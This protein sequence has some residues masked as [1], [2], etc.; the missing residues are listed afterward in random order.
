[1]KKEKTKY[2]ELSVYLVLRALV[3]AIMIRQ[4][5]EGNFENVFVCILTLILFII[6]IIIDRKL[7][8]KLPST[9]E[10]IIYFF[11]FAAWILGE[12]Q[13]FYGIFSYWDTILH[14]INGFICAAV[15]FA[16]I[17]ILNDSQKFFTNMS[18][19]FVVLVSICF[20]MTVG[21][22]W[23]FFEYSAD[24]ILQL[25]MQK[26]T[27]RHVVSSV[28]INEQEENKPIVLKNIEKTVI[29]SKNKNGDVIETVI[30]NG[31]VDIG[32]EDTI[33]DLGVNFIGAITF[34]ILGYFYIKDKEKYKFTESLMPVKKTEEEIKETKERDEMLV[35]KYQERKEL[36]KQKKDKNSEDNKISKDKK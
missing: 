24:R 21:V 12:I 14:T 15:G 27:I 23:E 19:I 11:I 8:I 32:V 29:Y 26:D 10:K 3:I 22:L 2:Y 18:P 28:L 4:L 33:E 7:N 17:D 36:K 9:L 6:P 1:M 30:N 35:K 31:Y 13:N 16:M 25:D 34:S 5:L 20:S